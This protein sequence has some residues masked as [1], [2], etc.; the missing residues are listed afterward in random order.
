MASSTPTSGSI[1]DLLQVT[2]DYPVRNR[3]IRSRVQHVTF[4][5]FATVYGKRRPCWEGCHGVTCWWRDIVF[6]VPFTKNWR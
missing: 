6:F 3:E 1:I 4:N 5:E 2:D